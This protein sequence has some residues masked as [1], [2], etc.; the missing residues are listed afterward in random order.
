VPMALLM[1]HMEFHFGYT[2]LRVGEAAIVTAR[3]HGL[4]AA[5]GAQA[6]PAAA[7]AT[8]EAPD[9]I[10]VETPA[11]YLPSVPEVAWRIRPTRVGR[12]ELRVQ[13]PGAVFS[14]AVVVSEEVARRSPVKPGDSVLAQVLNPSEPP[15]PGASG[16]ESIAVDYP[17]RPFALAGIDIGWAGVYLA[18]TLVFA[19]A[20]RGLFGVTM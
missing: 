9:G 11:V 12:Y 7:A 3:L 15:L 4:Q 5:T 16:L 18:M 8:I 1:L 2:G 17:E 20:L 6:T 10:I 14:K 13:L 19:L